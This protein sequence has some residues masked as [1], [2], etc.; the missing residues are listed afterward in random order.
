MY[1]A[2][3]RVKKVEDLNIDMYLEVIEEQ[4]QQ[5]VDYF[6]IHA[7]VLDSVCADGGEEDYG[8]CEPGWRDYGSVDDG[9]P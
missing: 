9:A 6:T 1:E 5:G 2:L 4:A 7:G 3:S 8:D